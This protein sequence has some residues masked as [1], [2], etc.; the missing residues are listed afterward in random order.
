MG[1]EEDEQV[2]DKEVIFISII[3]QWHIWL[4]NTNSLCTN[5]MG[6][7][8]FLKYIYINFGVILVAHNIHHFTILKFK[9]MT[10][11]QK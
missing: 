3:F 5:F 7:N 4:P 9:I 11:I 10:S 2:G 1:E 8:I 6:V